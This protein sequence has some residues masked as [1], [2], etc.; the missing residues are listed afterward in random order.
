[1]RRGLAAVLIALQFDARASGPPTERPSTPPSYL[2]STRSSG[3][4][5]FQ[6]SSPTRGQPTD[7]SQPRR[8]SVTPGTN[9]G[10]ICQ[11]AGKSVT[12]AKR[13]RGDC[14]S[15]EQQSRHKTGGVS[16]R[17]A[18]IRATSRVVSG[19]SRR[20]CGEQREHQMLPSVTGS[21]HAYMLQPRRHDFSR[22]ADAEISERFRRSTRFLRSASGTSM[23][24]PRVC[25]TVRSSSKSLAESDPGE[26][27]QP[28]TS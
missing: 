21:A 17:M 20:P 4:A 13:E 19:P 6:Q 26:V 22:H 25:K 24:S 8:R 16:C 27:G 1:M 28:S 3:V 5:G 15:G 11:T 14:T 18:T 7:P 12:A 9:R 2:A 23:S 10:R